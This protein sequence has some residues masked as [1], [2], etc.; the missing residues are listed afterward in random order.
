LILLQKTLLNIEGVGRMLDPE[1][2][3]WAV[4]HPVLK[5]ILRERYS[6]LR[7]LR[8]MRRRLPE[9]LHAAPEFPELIRDA[10]RQVARGEQRSVSDPSALAQQRDDAQRTRRLLAYGLLGSSL[11]IGSAVLWTQASQQGPWPAVVTGVIALLAFS[12]GWPRR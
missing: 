6:P 11:L 10:L 12:I 2:D 3:I 5:R 9:W 8:T 4:A 1:I 7:T